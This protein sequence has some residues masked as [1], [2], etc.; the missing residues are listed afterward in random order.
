MRIEDFDLLL[1]RWLAGE[2]TEEDE[3][4]LA[5]EL[6]A[7][8]EARLRFVE[9]SDQ[10][11]A[12]RVL[13]QSVVQA[14]AI[15]E[16][17]GKRRVAA[18]R[19]RRSP[20]GFPVL[21]AALAAASLVF[22]IL[23]LA[24]ALSS[25]PAPPVRSEVVRVPDAPAPVEERRR[26]LEARL[27]TIERERERLVLP[28]PADPEAEEKRRQALTRLETDRRSVEE[29]MRKAID[30]ARAKIPSAAPPPPPERKT[31]AAPS[32]VAVLER[33]EGE[34]AVVHAGARM[35]ARAGLEL[36][37]GQSLETV[38]AASSAAVAFP[39]R[40]RIQLGGDTEVR[41][42]DGRRLFVA[43]GVVAADVTKRPADRQMVFASLPGEAR[44]L[45]TRLR[46]VVDPSSMRLD[47]EEGKVRLLNR[48]TGRT[49]DVPSGHFAVAAAGIALVSR[50]LPID[51][52][53]L[54]ASQGTRVG[55]DWRPVKD[56]QA[57]GGEAL[58]CRGIADASKADPKT[59]AA[60]SKSWNREY[61]EF[62]FTAD[63]HR[64]YHVWLRGASLA[65]ANPTWFDQ[66]GLEAPTGRV[67]GRPWTDLT[68]ATGHMMNGHGT[69][70]GYWWIGGN[71]DG[72]GDLPP[73]TVRFSRPGP[74]VLRLHAFHKPILMRIDVLWLSATR[75]T[76]PEDGQTGPRR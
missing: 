43:R 41:E 15:R 6:R 55:T 12:L 64:D 72:G 19:L 25:R 69:R 1:A 9:L 23:V 68:G 65:E 3:A 16:E 46:V 14:E 63:A 71:A 75:S 66:M 40:T 29:E 30:E 34:V 54:L 76:R 48:L 18:R 67:T 45:G 32:A 61:V 36:L 51:E 7:S 73:T 44:V 59:P 70:T 47:V 42:L 33:I 22:G 39:D 38:G 4:R 26:E 49:V 13:A 17:F 50:S 62:R 35:A 28:P 56:D 74:Q 31:E 11:A 27:R 52:V 57:A 21:G 8:E 58:E 10:E 24:A 20:Q 2:T 37:A 53:V 5:A 60:D